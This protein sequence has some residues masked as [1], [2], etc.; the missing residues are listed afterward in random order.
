MLVKAIHNLRTGDQNYCDYLLEKMGQ[1]YLI[2]IVY[3]NYENPEN[4][5][6]QLENPIDLECNLLYNIFKAIFDHFQLSFFTE[7]FYNYAFYPSD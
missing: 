6:N 4:A 3:H 2:N 7:E 1:S 5:D